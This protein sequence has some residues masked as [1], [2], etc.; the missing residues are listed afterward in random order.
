MD[1]VLPKTVNIID[2]RDSKYFVCDYTGAFCL[3]RFFD[4]KSKKGCFC[5]LPVMLRYLYDK[6]SAAEFED[7]KHELCTFYVQPN[8]PMADV[9]TEFEVPLTPG[10]LHKYL[11]KLPKGGAWILVQK[12]QSVASFL[13][14]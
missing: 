14:K 13:K 1:R 6:L 12:S 5:S 8:I 7:A 10:A 3:Y 11:E 4:P 2:F 9:L